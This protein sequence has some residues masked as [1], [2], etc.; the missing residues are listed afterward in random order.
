MSAKQAAEGQRGRRR[1]SA[2]SARRRGSRAAGRRAP[3]RRRRAPAARPRGRSTGRSA[4]STRPTTTSASFAALV[5]LDAV[6][7]ADREPELDVLARAE[8]AGEARRLA[9]ERDP[10]RGGSGP[11][12]R[13]RAPRATTPSITT[14]PASGTS[15]P[16]SERESVDLP[17]PD[18]P[19]TTAS[20]PGANVGRD[21]GERDVAAVAAA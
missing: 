3:G 19:V 18:G 12:R 10:C 15:R 5:R 14:A 2:T 4:C 6:D 17:E 7:A 9:D 13:G 21:R 16:A 20:R 8:E 11:A 1:R